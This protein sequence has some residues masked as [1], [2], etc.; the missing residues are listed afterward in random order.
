METKVLRLKLF[1]DRF[2]IEKF[3]YAIAPVDDNGNRSSPSIYL[4]EAELIDNHYILYKERAVFGVAHTPQE[5]ERRLFD[6]AMQISKKSVKNFPQFGLFG[7]IHSHEGNVFYNKAEL[8]PVERGERLNFRK[9]RLQK[10][11]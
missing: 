8:M 5:A 2:S 10:K 11:K 4:T 3:A 1:G 7:K 6:L 9:E